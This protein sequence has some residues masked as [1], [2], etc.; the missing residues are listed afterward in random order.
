MQIVLFLNMK[1]LTPIS[2]YRLGLKLFSKSNALALISKI[3]YCKYVVPFQNKALL[4]KKFNYNRDLNCFIESYR[5]IF[6]IKEV[7]LL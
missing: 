6:S 3:S 2:Y 5:K 1:F 4:N 7:F